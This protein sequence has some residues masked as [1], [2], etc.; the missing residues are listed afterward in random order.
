[1][2]GNLIFIILIGLMLAFVFQN[3]QDVDIKFLIWKIST[4]RALVL[5]VTFAVGLVSGWLLG[6]PRRQKPGRS[7]KLR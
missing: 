2:L 3:I 7:R 4:S 1:M 5:L 6:L